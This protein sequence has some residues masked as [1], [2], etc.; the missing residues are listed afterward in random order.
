MITKWLRDSGLVVNESKTEVCLFHKNDQPQISITLQ[1]VSV[2]S[3]KSMN[4]L[5][6]I[7]DAKLNWQLQVSNATSKASKALF[8]L[9]LLKRFFNN[10]QMR[11]LLDA[12]FYSVL[13]YNTVWLTPTLASDLKH[14]LLSISANALRSCLMYKDFDISFDSIHKTQKKY[15]PAQIMYYQMS[16][17]LFKIIN[18]N[19]NDL[20]FETI[21]VLNQIVCSRRQLK[22]QILR[23]FNTK[24]GLNTTA[25]KLYHLNDLISFDLLNLTFVHFKKIMKIP[26]LKYGKT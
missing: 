2:T 10:Y 14:S 23:N 18:N 20:S 9:R 22:F 7:F 5:G 12:H 3:K 11:T 13:Y 17:N 24:I 25:N 15:T 6:V 19:D 26:F 8:A 4:V 21:T 1:G 16:L